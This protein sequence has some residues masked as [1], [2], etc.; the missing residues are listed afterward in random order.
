[1]IAK[2]SNFLNILLNSKPVQHNSGFF[3]MRDKRDVGYI[4]GIEYG[5][6]LDAN[7]THF[8]NDTYTTT[9]ED[10]S[11]NFGEPLESGDIDDKVQY[12]WTIQIHNWS[13]VPASEYS[14]N[15]NVRIGSGIRSRFYELAQNRFNSLMGSVISNIQRRGSVITGKELLNEHVTQDSEESSIVTIYDWKQYRPIKRD[16]KIEWHLGSRGR[17]HRSNVELANEALSRFSPEQNYA[18]I[19]REIKTSYNRGFN[20]VPNVSTNVLG[21]YVIE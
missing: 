12:S 10:L 6:Y 9:I 1:M 18:G 4:V 3:I 20:V 11:L 15:R 19:L 8:T 5:P 21:G 16:E 13:L 17:T 14:P 7:G 2:Q